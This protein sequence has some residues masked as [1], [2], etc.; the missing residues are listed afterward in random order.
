MWPWLRQA[1]G[2]PTHQLG[3][4][5]LQRRAVRALHRRFDGIGQDPARGLADQ[6]GAWQHHWRARHRGAVAGPAQFQHSFDV[7]RQTAGDL[8]LERVPAVAQPGLF[9]V[10]AMP[11]GGKAA[12]HDAVQH[13]LQGQGFARARGIHRPAGQGKP[14]GLVDVPGQGGRG[15]RVGHLHPVG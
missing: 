9:Q 14:V 5:G 4:Q 10:R 2:Q 6:R 1:R 11:V 15:V 7:L 12:H 13:Q 3:Q 8:H